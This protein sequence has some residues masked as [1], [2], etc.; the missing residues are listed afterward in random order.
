M[1]RQH[2]T[3]AASAATLLIALGAGGARAADVTTTSTAA[4]PDTTV[5]EIVVVGASGAGGQRKQVAAYAITTAN[6]QA[7]LNAAPSSAADLVKIVPGLFAETTGGTAGPNIEVRGFPTAGDAP[8]VTLQLDGLP[9]YPVST[10]SFLDNSSQFRLDDTIKRVEATIGG[11]AV[12]WGNAQPGATVNFTEKNGKTDPG[13]LLRVSA[14]SGSLYRVDGYYGGQIADGWYGSVGGFYRTD[15]G[16]RDTQ[17][18]ADQGGQVVATLTHD[19][20]N[21]SITLYGRY[22]NDKNAFFSPIPLLSSNG[23]NTISAFPG[24][25]PLTGTLIGNADRIVTFDTAPGQSQTV[26]LGD[27]RGTDTKIIGVDFEKT[28][29]RLEITNKL[30]FLSGADEE[31]AQFTGANPETLGQF[32]AGEVA[33]ANGTPA[34]V[35]ANGLASSGTANLVGGG[36]LTNL[37]QEVI[38][39]GVWFV[40]KKVTA[41]QDEFRLSYRLTDNN[42]VT[43]GL[44][45]ADYTSKD[46]WHLGNDQLLTLQ[47]N[48]VPVDI[49]LNNGVQA[50][51]GDGIYAPSNF[52]INN[53]YNGQNIAGIIADDWQVTDRFKI[54]G[55]VRFE[56]ESINA[57]EQNTTTGFIGSNPNQL[58]DYGSNY[59]IAGSHGVNF[60]ANEAAYAIEGTY[61]VIHNLNA[62]VG[63]NHG[64]VLPTF[65]DIRSNVFSTTY[66]DQVQ[67]GIKRLSSFYSLYLTGFYASFSGQPSQQILADG[68]QINYL[69]ASKTEGLEFQGAIRPINGLDLAIDGDYQHGRYTAGGPGITGSEVLRQPDFQFRFT[70]TYT[71]P[72]QWGPMAAYLTVTYVD[73]RFADVFN[74]QPLP[75]YTTLDI[76]LLW[77]LKNGIDLQLTG[78]NVTN[79]LGITEGNTRVLGSGVSAGG[80]FLGR[81]LFGATYTGSISYHF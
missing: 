41:F 25:N 61:E 27:G 9:I 26:D 12:L 21:G 33:Q 49:T 47:N 69:T 81:P 42:T 28:I 15:N 63:F 7:I 50:T 6:E 36:A 1:T 70:P 67:G 75:S 77:K 19:I 35:A 43:A 79:T 3:Y 34:V 76:G 80:V 64:F 10:L 29:D 55:G 74:L 51:N 2:L 46:V 18:P 57:T 24:F 37:N 23:G 62:F 32:I 52:S 13:G 54:D 71:V 58:Y 11:P 4:T 5:G 20:D 39:V 30:S 78:T 72:T 40:D 68:T 56:H 73:K 17:F 44:Y 31:I 38:G 8:F 45:F 60:D 16:V 59:L 48:A 66:V 22:T 65:D 14:G 53:S